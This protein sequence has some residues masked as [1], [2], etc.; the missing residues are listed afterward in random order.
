M[1]TFQD[2]IRFLRAAGGSPSPD[3]KLTYLFYEEKGDLCMKTWTGS[4]F[5]DKVWVAS[6]VRSGTSAA[7][8]ELGFKAS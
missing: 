7:F 6:G 3:G 8:A 5:S 1:S 2:V 4:E